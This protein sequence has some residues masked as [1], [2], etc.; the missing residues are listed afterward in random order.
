MA[1]TTAPTTAPV[2]TLSMAPTTAPTT[3]LTTAPATAMSESGR[4]VVAGALECAR[5]LHAEGGVR[6]FYR[7]FWPTMLRAGPVAGAIMPTFELTLAWLERHRHVDG[8][9]GTVR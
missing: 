4:R 1:L 3:A 2:T 7:G 6:R 9:T 5:R 8:A